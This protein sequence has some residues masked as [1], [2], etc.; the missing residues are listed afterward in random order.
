MPRG[1]LTRFRLTVF[2]YEANEADIIQVMESKWINRISLQEEK[3]PSTGRLHLQV[4]I[5]TNV[6]ITF[7]NLRTRLE[8]LGWDRLR[9]F[10]CEASIWANFQYTRKD[11][12]Y[13]G[14]FRLAR[15]TFTRP[16]DSGQDGKRVSALSAMVSDIKS[17]RSEYYIAT[18]HTSAFLRHSRGVQRVISLLS[19]ARSRSQRT[20]IRCAWISGATGVGKSFWA[21]Q[22]AVYRH[23]HEGFFSLAM[24]D[25]AGVRI[26]FTGYNGQRVLIIDDI[27]YDQ[28]GR[29]LF[30]RQWMLR[31]LDTYALQVPVHGSMVYAQWDTVIFTSNYRLDQMYNDPAI[32]R[33]FTLIH[34]AQTREEL[35][36]FRVDIPCRECPSFILPTDDS[37]LN[38]NDNL[39]Q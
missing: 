2:G 32:V 18:Q 28:Q 35:P 9:V 37:E 15:G 38:N 10:S 7:N 1:Y 6:R 22:Y 3:C 13:T 29:I 27:G 4:F 23:G 24:P 21:R 25:F 33:R 11:E 36:D 5:E 12:S 17:G 16:R 30:G 39:M 31:V 14:R 19:T 20:Q 8:R 26:W 34:D